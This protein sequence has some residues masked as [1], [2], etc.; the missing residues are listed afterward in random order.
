MVSIFNFQFRFSPSAN[1]MLATTQNM[2]CLYSL[3]MRVS[4]SYCPPICG[5]RYPRAVQKVHQTRETLTLDWIVMVLT[6]FALIMFALDLL[7]CL[8]RLWYRTFLSKTEEW[9]L[10]PDGVSIWLTRI[11]RKVR[12][13]TQSPTHPPSTTQPRVKL[14]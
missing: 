5:R 2:L 1:A 9:G 8:I 11:D 7:D 4:S 14:Q 3:L 6:A 12:C 13:T 10:S